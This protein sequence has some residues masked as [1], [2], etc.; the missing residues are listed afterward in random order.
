MNPKKF[1]KLGWI[2]K[3]NMVT[4]MYQQEL[5]RKLFINF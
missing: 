5:T 3:Y 4:E 1:R 2:L